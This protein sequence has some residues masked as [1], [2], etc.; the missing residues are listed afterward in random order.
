MDEVEADGGRIEGKDPQEEQQRSERPPF[1]RR[2]P[3]IMSSFAIHSAV[4][5][6]SERLQLLGSCPICPLK[7]A[8]QAS[9]VD[10]VN[11]TVDHGGIVIGKGPIVGQSDPGTVPQLRPIIRT[12]HGKESD[13]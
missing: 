11:E 9:A 12:G 7:F 8:F 3:S 4:E 5:R 6:P 1:P 13:S 2:I 10:V